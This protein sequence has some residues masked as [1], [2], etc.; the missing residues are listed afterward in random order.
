MHLVELRRRGCRILLSL[1]SNALTVAAAP[2]GVRN[3]QNGF[4]LRL[5]RV[6]RIVRE[7]GRVLASE[8]ALELLRIDEAE[9]VG[10]FGWR[11]FQLRVRLRQR[12]RRL[13]RKWWTPTVRSCRTGPRRLNYRFQ[14]RALVHISPHRPL[15]LLTGMTGVQR[16]TGDRRGKAPSAQLPDYFDSFFRV[17]GGRA[18]R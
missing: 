17:V 14:G 8:E 4:Q 12:R 15:L 11:L 5:P 7:V 3:L 16:M 13:R 2:P 10:K 6:S 9:Q 18:L 1:K